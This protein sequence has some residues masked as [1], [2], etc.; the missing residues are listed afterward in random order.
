[1]RE[2]AGEW[3][4]A[5]WSCMVHMRYPHVQR[6]LHCVVVFLCLENFFF[7]LVE[8]SWTLSFCFWHMCDPGWSVSD[9]LVGIRTGR[10]PALWIEAG[11]IVVSGLWFFHKACIR[12]CER[13]YC[14][15]C[16]CIARINIW[17]R[18]HANKHTYIHS[19]SRSQT[20][21]ARYW[22][23]GSSLRGT[24]CACVWV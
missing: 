11:C 19:H 22:R 2:Y 3:L 24:K 23:T 21:N 16:V 20:R 13:A 6:C 17:A 5:W 9:L 1:M 7:R 10:G 8:E 14:T 15:P 12:R 4:Y 18:N